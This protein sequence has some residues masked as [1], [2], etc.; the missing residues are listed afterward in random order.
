MYSLLTR[1]VKTLHKSNSTDF[2][3]CLNMPIF[4]QHSLM[5]NKEGP[6]GN[7]M[8]IVISSPFLLGHHFRH[9]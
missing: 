6:K 1:T 8:Y 4:Y 7:E 2:I 9:E 5:D 3:A